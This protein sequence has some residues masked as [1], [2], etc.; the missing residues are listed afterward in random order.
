MIQIYYLYVQVLAVIIGIIV[1]VYW[2]IKKTRL[3]KWED[4]PKNNQ[5]VI[6]KNEAK[7][8]FWI[9]AIGTSLCIIIFVFRIPLLM[10]FPSLINKDFE[11]ITGTVIS[12]GPK[13]NYDRTR[14]TVEIKDSVSDEILTIYINNCPYIYEEDVIVVDYL[15]Y[16]KQGL[17][18]EE[19]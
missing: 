17:L 16:S 14:R 10:D 7:I 5:K 18:R 1:F 3:I 19:R 12:Q 8:N 6:K 9:K 11:G 15:K 13:K 4:A 2:D